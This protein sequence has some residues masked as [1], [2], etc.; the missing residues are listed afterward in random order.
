MNGEGAARMTP[1]YFEAAS[2]IIA[3]ILLGRLLEARARGRTADAVKKLDTIKAFEVLDRGADRRW[4]Q[5]DRLC[6]LGQVF[7]L[8]DRRINTHA[9]ARPSAV[10]DY[11]EKGVPASL[12]I[13]PHYY[14]TE[15]EI[16]R[17]CGAVRVWMRN[18]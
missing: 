12:R 7:A 16:D 4:R 8:R 14:N 6:R 9:Q 18:V 5:M 17:L 2:V 13:S 10:I 15:E 1:V 3:L 11:D